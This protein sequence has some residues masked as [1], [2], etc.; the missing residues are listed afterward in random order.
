MAYSITNLAFFMDRHW[1]N[2]CQLYTLLF[3][4]TPWTSTKTF[5][6]CCNIF[7]APQLKFCL[8]RV[9]NACSKSSNID[10]VSKTFEYFVNISLLFSRRHA[11]WY[12]ELGKDHSSVTQRSVQMARVQRYRV[13]R[14]SKTDRIVR[15]RASWYET[16]LWWN[17]R[18]SSLFLGIICSVLMSRQLIT[19]L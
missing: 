9:K 3:R 14:K 11:N 6:Y 2:S 19:T 15:E 13:K 12:I 10:I 5:Y 17:V 1:G 4:T 16:K 7:A 18:Y 8:Q